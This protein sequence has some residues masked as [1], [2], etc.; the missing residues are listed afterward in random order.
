MLIFI[1]IYCVFWITAY[2][3]KASELGIDGIVR[4]KAFAEQNAAHIY[5][6]D[7]A[8]L[9]FGYYRFSNNAVF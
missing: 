3:I 2:L 4:F 5:A 1:P 6:M 9:Y 8:S 7:K